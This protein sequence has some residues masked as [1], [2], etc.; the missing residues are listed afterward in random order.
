MPLGGKG[1]RLGKAT[2]ARRPWPTSGP[3]PTGPW[4]SL[5]A[6]KGSETSRDL[7]LL[8]INKIESRGESQGA[9]PTLARKKPQVP[10]WGLGNLSFAS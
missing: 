9:S 2:K 1:I 7:S 3:L 4:V 6:F 10:S 8:P 5:V